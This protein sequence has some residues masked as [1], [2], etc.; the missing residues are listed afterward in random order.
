MTL[1]G[2]GGED[3]GV[4]CLGNLLSNQGFPLRY[5]TIAMHCSG[6]ESLIVRISRS[7]LSMMLARLSRMHGA[8][9]RGELLICC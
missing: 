3:E 1:S 4:P 9:C 6:Q 8:V 7:H 2:F 5:G